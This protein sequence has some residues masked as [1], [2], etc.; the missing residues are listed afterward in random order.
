[1]PGAHVQ[2]DM[3]GKTGTREW[4]PISGNFQIGCPHDC[5]YCYAKCS[6]LER[7]IIQYEWEWKEMRVMKSKLTETPRRLDGRIMFPTTHDITP[8]NLQT[9]LAYLNGWL[10]AGNEFLIVSKPHL[11]CVKEMCARL[12]PFRD[13]ITFRF[14]IGSLDD[15]VLK[16]WEPGAPGYGERLDSLRYAHHRGFRTSVSCEPFLDDKVAELAEAVSPYV[17]DTVWIGKMNHIGKRVNTRGW[18]EQGYAF[19][20]RVKAAQTDTEIL[21]LYETLKSNPKIRW[22][23]SIKHVV[24]LPEEAVG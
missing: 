5:R 14:T 9:A 3:T 20:E 21:K 24:G 2:L 4:A 6:A 19:L 13:S 18:G 23:D 17:T 10:K 7:G 15:E 12:M 11:E 8:E 22:K 1:M 16:F